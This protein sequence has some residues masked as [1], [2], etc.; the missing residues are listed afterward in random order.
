M[1]LKKS[2]LQQIGQGIVNM[3]TEMQTEE[4]ASDEM[5]AEQARSIC[6]DHGVTFDEVKPEPK[7]KKKFTVELRRT[8]SEGVCVEVEADNADDAHDIALELDEDTLEWQYDDGE[9]QVNDV[10]LS[11]PEVADELT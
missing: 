11:T 9:T 6:E 1:K 3:L 7:A 4:F 10:Y 8:S 5:I 2:Q